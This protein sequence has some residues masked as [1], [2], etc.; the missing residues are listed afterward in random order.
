M[1][2]SL[3]CLWHSHTFSTSKPSFPSSINTCGHSSR[4]TKDPHNR[5]GYTDLPASFALGVPTA[6]PKRCFEFCE[7]IAGGFGGLGSLIKGATP[8]YSLG[9]LVVRICQILCFSAEMFGYFEVIYWFSDGGGVVSIDSSTFC[10][11]WYLM[12][13]QRPSW[14]G[15]TRL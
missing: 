7:K 15:N 5:L 4:H 9:K 13:I 8:C 1:F 10:R 12:Q 3:M 14:D 11:T 6:T 2:L